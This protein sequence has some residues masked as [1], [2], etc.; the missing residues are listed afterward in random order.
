VMSVTSLLLI[1]YFLIVFPVLVVA[2]IAKW[3]DWE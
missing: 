1:S 3:K 2:K